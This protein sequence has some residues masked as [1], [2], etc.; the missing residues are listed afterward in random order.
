LAPHQDRL[1]FDPAPALGQLDKELRAFVGQTAFEELCR[2][3]TFQQGKKG[4]LPFA[5]EQV[6]SH[7][8]HRVQVDVVAVNWQSRDIL[9]G[10][11]K[12]GQKKVGRA[13][14]KELIARKQDKVRLDLTTTGQPWRF[15]FVLF[16]QAELTAGAQKIAEENN[17]LLVDLPRLDQD[18]GQ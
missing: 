7:W 16:A 14:V 8:S 3:W 5:P 17:V 1:P 13:V 11:C 18:L 9:L 4:H 12:W 2:L 10:E 15:H 6:G